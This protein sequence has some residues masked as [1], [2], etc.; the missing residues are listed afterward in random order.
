VLVV[1]AVGHFLEMAVL[2]LYDLVSGGT[3]VGEVTWAAQL[4]ARHRL[5]VSLPLS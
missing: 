1:A 2:G 4:L 5:H 3:V